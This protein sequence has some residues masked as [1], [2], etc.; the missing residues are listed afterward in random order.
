MLWI[1]VSR[2]PLELL[3]IGVR[4]NVL[5]KHYKIEGIKHNL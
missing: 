1:I 3:R 5:Q 4:R 2:Q